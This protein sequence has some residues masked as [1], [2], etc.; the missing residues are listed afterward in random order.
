[1][2]ILLTFSLLISA[3]SCA[4]E[5][6]AP[7]FSTEIVESS[8]ESQ[9]TS[10]AESFEESQEES[11]GESR[12]DEISSMSGLSESSIVDSI[13][14]Y[15]DFSNGVRVKVEYNPED[16]GKYYVLDAVE[17][18]RLKQLIKEDEWKVAE[19][20]PTFGSPS[21]VFWI[22]DYYNIW[23]FNP[24]GDDQMLIVPSRSNLENSE[25]TLYWVSDDIVEDVLAYL[26]TL[27]PIQE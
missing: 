27:T 12:I 1:M 24:W 4:V 20:I 17:S 19:D 25:K 11:I 10:I 8:L 3:V 15:P 9:E 7:S 16:E 6:T 2:M 18:E 13:P 26:D 5:N 21:C 23:F 22:E 14:L